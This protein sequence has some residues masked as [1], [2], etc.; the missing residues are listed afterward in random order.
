MQAPMRAPVYALPPKELRTPGWMWTLKKAMNGARTA[1]ADFYEFLATVLCNSMNMVRGILEPCWFAAKPGKLRVAIHVDDPIACGSDT[2]LHTFW[3]D[4]EKFVLLRR[5][6]RVNRESI[7][8]YLGR[9]YKYFEAAKHVGYAVRH[10]KRY[11]KTCMDVYGILDTSKPKS[12]PGRFEGSIPEEEIHD[13][14]KA[15][16]RLFRSQI[17][18]PHTRA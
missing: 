5:Y 12:T 3:T 9:E 8:Q 6:G 16:H 17:S 10:P 13:L 2:E 15:E 4:L 11:F 7:V 1:S 18:V 14:G